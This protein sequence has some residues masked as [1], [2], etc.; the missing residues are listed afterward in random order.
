MTDLQYSPNILLVMDCLWFHQAVLF[1]EPIS[2][3]IVKPSLTPP[4]QNSQTSLESL[5]DLSSTPPIDD[6]SSVSS[7]TSPTI[8][9]ANSMEGD[10]E[11]DDDLEPSYKRPSR[12]SLA[13]ITTRSQSL[14]PSTQKISRRNLRSM[15]EQSPLKQTMS[16]KT[17]ME[18]EFEE[19]KGFMDLGFK[20]KKEKLSPRMMKVLPGLQ[21]LD[22]YKEGKVEDL[23]GKKQARRQPYLSEAWL[24]NRPDSPL[25]SWRVPRVSTS[26]D[27]KKHLKSW[28]RTV[29]S[30][31]ELE[32]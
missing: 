19:V 4:Q 28:A 14:S 3:P 26:N 23:N 20:F 12:L 31:I 17:L 24:I 15:D 7:D 29:A 1:T 10:S 13:S 30:S 27:M 6:E 25:L 21:R 5:S 11:V 16:C 22:E 32:Y 9:K 2:L 8:S 18:L